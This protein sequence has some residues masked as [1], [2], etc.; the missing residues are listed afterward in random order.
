[1][2]YLANDKLHDQLKERYK[3]FHNQEKKFKLK[4]EEHEDEKD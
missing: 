2:N 4:G 1:M 3:V